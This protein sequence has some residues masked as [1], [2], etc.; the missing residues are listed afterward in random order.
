MPKKHVRIS[1]LT[2]GTTLA[3]GA[4]GWGITPFEGGHHH[5]LN[6]VIRPPRA[7]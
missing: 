7:R 6:L 3:E 1:H 2:S 5:D 4:V